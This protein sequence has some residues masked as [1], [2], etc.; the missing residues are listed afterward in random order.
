MSG[1][2]RKSQKFTLCLPRQFRVREEMD[3]ANVRLRKQGVGMNVRNG[4]G[5]AGSFLSR[6]QTSSAEDRPDIQRIFEKAQAERRARNGDSAQ[7][8]QNEPEHPSAVVQPAGEAPTERAESPVEAPT[9]AGS[10]PPDGPQREDETPTL[11]HAIRRWLRGDRNSDNRQQSVV[12]ERPSRLAPPASER[13]IGGSPQFSERRRFQSDVW[14]PA[15]DPV[16]AYN[17]VRGNL[18]IVALTTIAGAVLG[19]V[20]ALSM[21]KT[22]ISY[23]EVLVDPR[24]IKVSDRDLTSQ[25]LPS[26]ATL[27]L[28]ENQVRLMYAPQ[29]M[30]EVV[31]Q[32]DLTNDPRFETEPLGLFALIDTLKSLVRGGDD[33]TGNANAATADD[34]ANSLTIARADRTFVISIAAET[35]DPELSAEIANA[36]V[37]AYVEASANLTSAT[38]GRAET[39]ITSRLDDLRADVETA[40]RAVES[41]RTQNDLVESQGRLITD[42]QILRLN[43]QLAAVNAQVIELQARAQTIGETSTDAVIGGGVPEAINSPVISEL[44]AQNAQLRQQAESLATRLGP[45]HPQR[46]AIESQLSGAREQL[47]AELRRIAAS[48][49]A[50]LRRARQQQEQLAD[51]LAQMKVRQGDISRELVTLRQLEREAAAKRNVY[52]AYLVRAG[53][54][55]EQKD[56]NTTNISVISEAQPP[57][58][59]EGP[60]RSMTAIL[61][62]FLGFVAGLLIGAMRGVWQDMRARR[63][64]TIY[65]SATVESNG[66]ESR[67]NGGALIGNEQPMAVAREYPTPYYDAIYR[68]SQPWISYPAPQHWT[69]AHTGHQDHDEAANA[70]SQTAEP[71][72]QQTVAPVQNAPSMAG[73]DDLSEHDASPQHRHTAQ[74]SAQADIEH[75]SRE[76]ERR[77]LQEMR[78]TVRSLRQI[79]DGL[80]ARADG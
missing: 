30:Q 19:V 70:S 33:E 52:E 20:I 43:D 8:A 76:D 66:S 39:E 50:E 38:A 73:P 64:G 65:Y 4:T 42:E 44:R 35:R 15:I 62:T 10:A 68:Q 7:S 45:R 56:I 32:L 24:D 22:Y 77:E 13:H 59:P 57:L 58:Q 51:R 3:A 18:G 80:A 75:R 49:D 41:F 26:D 37:S 1:S 21:P 27:A 14:R 12:E 55:G 78:E 46:I 79:L 17:G 63:E 11:A 2:R 72:A 40:E 29:V 67:W 61:F 48:A 69:Q 5:K 23:A 9:A 25:G 71:Q 28:I 36:V 74:A 31:E 16:A 34:L 6:G 54:A 47:A 60:S 53:D